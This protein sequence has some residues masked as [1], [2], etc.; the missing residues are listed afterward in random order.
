MREPELQ[1]LLEAAQLRVAGVRLLLARPRACNPDE[2][3]TLFREAHGYLEWLR[4]SL[5]GAGPV[6]PNLRRGVIGIAGEIRQTGVLLE[7]AARLG[8][9]WLE[10]WRAL[11]PE[12][13][14]YGCASPL[15]IRRRI[16]FLG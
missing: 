4:D 10:H 8:R 5:G 12:Y 16:S 14:P 15:A 1:G 6:D 7:Q 3:I 2:C 9:R 13:T 11:S